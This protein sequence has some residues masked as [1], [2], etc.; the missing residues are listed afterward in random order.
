MA[1]QEIKPGLSCT[2]LVEVAVQ[3]IVNDRVKVFQAA[4]VECI[5]DVS[6][7]PRLLKPGVHLI[8][9]LQL[10][11][12]VGHRRRKPIVVRQVTEFGILVKLKHTL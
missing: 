5:E 12:E 7:F 10:K 9:V 4:A 1:K 11:Q 8:A 2:N 3:P 6:T